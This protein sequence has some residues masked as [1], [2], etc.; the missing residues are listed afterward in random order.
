MKTDSAAQDKE[1]SKNQLIMPGKKATS[2]VDC[3]TFRAILG[4]LAASNEEER[5]AEQ[6]VNLLKVR[7]IGEHMVD[8]VELKK[9]MASD[10]SP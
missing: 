9:L 8:L 10:P 2:L 3:R 1:E 5:A 4:N 7:T 6:L